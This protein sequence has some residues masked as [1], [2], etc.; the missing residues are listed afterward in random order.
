MRHPLVSK[1]RT[2]WIYW[3]CIFTWKVH[4]L[5]CRNFFFCIFS[6]SSYMVSRKIV[7]RYKEDT[8]HKLIFKL[9]PPAYHSNTSSKK[10]EKIFGSSFSQQVY[11]RPELLEVK[12]H[13]ELRM[14]RMWW[15][16]MAPMLHASKCVE[17]KLISKIIESADNYY[18]R[19][20]TE[21][22]MQG[23]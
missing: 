9:R 10:R 23:H 20:L 4:L 11:V 3:W 22:N 21:A 13:G 17:V 16:D 12:S 2:S 14:R 1:N 19:A 5:L 6:S 7:K 15:N 8:Y 18:A